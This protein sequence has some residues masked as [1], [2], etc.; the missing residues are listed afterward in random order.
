[1]SM[2]TKKMRMLTAVVM[3][4][5]REKVVKT[6]LDAGV[7]K[8]IHIDS[9]PEDKM[10]KLRSHEA[11][12]T[13]GELTDLRLRIESLMRTGEIMTPVL[14][15]KEV[16]EAV[17]V[18]KDDVKRELDGLSSALQKVKDEQKSISQNLQNARALLEYAQA[19]SNEYIDLR[20]GK[21]QR[22]TPENLKEK[23]AVFGGVFFAEADGSCISLTLS[24]DRKRV[25]EVI[26]KFDWI[27]EAE[28]KVQ[29]EAKA[30]A[31]EILKERISEYEKEL[32]ALKEKARNKI[33]KK[34]DELVLLW[35]R[36]R[37][38]ELCESVE[39]Y[40][41]YTR[42]TTLFSGWVPD[43]DSG[44]IDKEIKDATKGRC[45]IEWTDA[46]DLP[47]EK[48]PVD[49][50]SPAFMKPFSHLVKNYGTPE[51]GSINPTPFTLVAYMLMFMLMFADLGQG[52]VLLMIGIIGTLYYKKHP[53][54][55]DGIISRY[56]CSL[57][58][59][60]GPSSMVGGIVF[61]STFGYNLFPA[62]WFNYHA[63][64]NGHAS[65]EGFVKSIYDILGIT[66]WFGIGVIYMGLLLNWINLVRK[67]KF[68]DLVFD[69]YG[70]VGGYLYAL[71]IWFSYGFVKSNY[72]VFP[73][74]PWF[75]PSLAVGIL[76]VLF[77]VPAETI[78]HKAKHKDE[79]IKA[80]KLIMDTIMEFIV[81]ALEIFSGFLA[82][83]LS[84]MRVAGLGIAHVSLMTAFEDM[85]G[86][87]SIVI[88]QVLIMI[89]GNV[90]VIALEG[91][92]AGIQSLRL[93]YYEFFT[94][95][96]TGRGMPYDPI[97]ITNSTEN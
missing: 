80:G 49:L 53:M 64:V 89:I 13:K 28:P 58:I 15:K 9:L 85:A 42:N 54:K 86:L 34:E 67:R 11:P 44:F 18:D 61:G 40:F 62:L 12:I 84:F 51:Y 24:R 60:L 30:K 57:L 92:S 65:P 95:F 69:K 25:S 29:K 6:L 56:L 90:L 4:E 88:F 55:K 73:S 46:K 20:V 48:V 35:K 68:V 3:D 39:S 79:K 45:I 43:G 41:S 37:S 22:E 47:R 93:N 16:D 83:T 59:W 1:M 8:F 23:L 97:S 50:K 70:L 66:V 82:N 78:A 74:A 31:E 36:V 77:K 19:K 32:N 7:M 26:D 75:M 10:K 33:E 76:I 2:F 81:E 71:G 5:D 52:F 63:V 91:L 96:F 94:K 27:E 14:N 72:K 87:T 17:E 21:I 38:Q